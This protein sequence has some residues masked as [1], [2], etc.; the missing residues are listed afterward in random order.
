MERNELVSAGCMERNE[1][2]SAGCMERK[3]QVSAGM[4]GRFRYDQNWSCG[5]VPLGPASTLNPQIPST[6]RPVL[7]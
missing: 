2:V 7:G 3:E 1:L 5:T 4:E 6:Y